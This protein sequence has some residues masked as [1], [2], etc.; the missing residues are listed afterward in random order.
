MKFSPLFGH[1]FFRIGPS[2]MDF[3]RAQVSSSSRLATIMT[4]VL[5]SLRVQRI[6]EENSGQKIPPPK[7]YFP[8]D[9]IDI[10][11]WYW[12]CP[13]VWHSWL[14]V[15]TIMSKNISAF[16]VIRRLLFCWIRCVRFT[17]HRDVLLLGR[18][19]SELGWLFGL[20]DLFLPTDPSA[21]GKLNVSPLFGFRTSFALSLLALFLTR[22]KFSVPQRLLQ[23]CLL[24]LPH[25]THIERRCSE[26]WSV[27][28]SFAATIDPKRIIGP[29]NGSQI[30]ARKQFSSPIGFLESIADHSNILRNQ[31]TIFHPDC[32]F[33][34]RTMHIRR[35]LQGKT[36]LPNWCGGVLTGLWQKLG[37]TQPLNQNK[38]PVLWMGPPTRRSWSVFPSDKRSVTCRR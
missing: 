5:D 18:E 3:W 16:C 15:K 23:R 10:C 13:F 8:P 6:S 4:P 7:S 14:N 37:D 29:M 26:G 20:L 32:K 30:D 9:N 17:L 27:A 2:S 1:H 25:T 11:E 38:L 33:S 24:S 28:W 12:D 35:R 21:H 19:D 36:F 22:Q 31:P 34:P